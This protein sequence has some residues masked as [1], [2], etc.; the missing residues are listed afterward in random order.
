MYQVAFDVE[1]IEMVESRQQ[2]WRLDS[3]DPVVRDVKNLRNTI[4]NCHR[5]VLI[6]QVYFRSS[7]HP[8]CN[9]KPTAVEVP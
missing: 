5:I 1:R 8:I 2:V 3:S 9:L 4:A 7:L 6:K